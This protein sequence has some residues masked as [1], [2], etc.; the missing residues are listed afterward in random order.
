MSKAIAWLTVRVEL[1]AIKTAL[2]GGTG[3]SHIPVNTCPF[4]GASLTSHCTSHVDLL[5][6]GSCATLCAA[7]QTC[8]AQYHICMCH[9][10]IERN[11][12]K[13][14]EGRKHPS[15][16]SPE[17]TQA[18]MEEKPC[19]EAVRTLPKS[20]DDVPGGKKGSDTLA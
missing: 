6:T 20:D 14:P 12:H 16:R 9:I 5:F 1:F 3:I 17:D 15:H 18:R 4:F 7:K 13:A 8:A 19:D 11:I 10:N 2:S